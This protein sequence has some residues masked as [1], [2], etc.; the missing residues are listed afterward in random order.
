MIAFTAT[1]ELHI[2]R[3]LVLPLERE[4]AWALIAE[5]HE[6][7]TW[8]AEE[9]ELDVEAG[10]EGTVTVEGERR[11]AVVEEVEPCRRVVLRWRDGHGEESVVELTLDDE[12]AGGTRLIVLELPVRTLVAVGAELATLP[13][14]AGP[15]LLECA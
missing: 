8:F 2:R 9:V 6:L 12:P 14:T 15:S 5:A 11:D 13:T 1:M 10:A 7:E 4:D 3:E